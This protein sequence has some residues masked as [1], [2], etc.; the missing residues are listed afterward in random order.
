LSPLLAKQKAVVAKDYWPSVMGAVTYREKLYAL[1]FQVFTELIY[2]TEDLLK[3]EGQPIPA[4]DWTWDKL[5]E[6]ARAVTRPGTG[7][8]AGQWG[9]N[10]VLGNFRSLG[11]VQI[12]AQ[13]GKLFDNDADPRSLSL[14]PA[15]AAG[16]QWIADMYSKYRVIVQA[17]DATAAGFANTS[18]MV[19][20]GQVAFN[21]SSLT[22]RGYRQNTGFTADVQMLPKGRVSQ[23]ATAR[24]DCLTLPTASKNP[25]QALS[26]MT[27]NSGPAGQRLMIPVVDQF[28]SVESIATSQEWLQFDQINR[29]A[30]VEMIRLAKPVPSTPAWVDIQTG[31][32]DPLFADLRAG[33]TTALDGLREIK[34]K[35]DDLLRTMA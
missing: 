2:Y 10:M 31:A 25:D 19:T 27:H 8:Q 9:V 30:A 7:S 17:E 6:S 18:Q 22:W 12:W 29:Q 4:K 23:V 13:G 15:G 1:P 11:L 14:D 21:Y 20:A 5:L 32:F 28:P 35:V 26:L 24:A 16:L 34:P 33:K 3:R